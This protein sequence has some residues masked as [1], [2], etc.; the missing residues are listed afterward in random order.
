MVDC[1]IND[2]H[3]HS[4]DRHAATDS[5]V[6]LSTRQSSITHYFLND[7]GMNFATPFFGDASA[8]IGVAIVL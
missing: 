6:F 1:Q 2:S 4:T 7:A 3:A 5:L 8:I